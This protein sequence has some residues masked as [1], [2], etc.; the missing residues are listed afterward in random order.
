MRENIAAVCKY[1]F[2]MFRK[3]KSLWLWFLPFFVC[4]GF[5]RGYEARTA[6]DREL[7]LE[8]NGKYVTVSGKVLKREQREDASYRVILGDCVGDDFTLEKLQV[9]WEIHSAESFHFLAIGN[10]ISVS[11]TVQ[12][13]DEA[14]NPGEFDH[15][16][17]ARSQKL[18]YRMFAEKGTLLKNGHSLVREA[19]TQVREQSGVILEKTADP[20]DCGIYRA[21]IL[22]DSGRMDDTL[23]E[24]YRD[25]GAAHLLAVSGLHLSLISAATY[26]VLRKLGAGYGVSGI[27]GT[28]VLMLYGILVGESSSVLRA[29]IMGICGFAASYLGRTYDLMSAWSLALILLLWESPYRMLQAGVQ[30]SFGALAGIGWLAPRLMNG[31][32]GKTWL[33]S[34][35]MQLM[36]IPILLYHDFQYPFYGILLNFLMVPLMGGVVA[37]GTAGIALG[38]V[39]MVSGSWLSGVS[40]W[41]A[42]RLAL[43]GGHMI[44]AWYEFCCR[45]AGHLPGNVIVAGRPEIWKIGVYYGILLVTVVRCGSVEREKDEKN[46]AA[47]IWSKL[48]G[49]FPM[50]AIL[51]MLFIPVPVSGLKV[52]F[53]DVGQGDGICIQTGKISCLMDGGSTDQKQLGEY[54]LVPFLHSQGITKVDYAIVSHGDADHI[55]GLQYL[56]EKR[57]VEIEHLILPEAGRGED[58]YEQLAELAKE[59][60]CHVHWMVRG[61]EICIDSFRERKKLIFTCLSPEKGMKTED[62]NEHSVVLKLDYENFHMLLTGDM[63][64]K[65]EREILENYDVK[66]LGETQVLKVAHHGSDTSSSKSWIQVIRP[67]WA[68]ISY[69]ENNRYGH[70][71]ESVMERLRACQTKIFETAKNGAIWLETDGNT[72]VWSTFK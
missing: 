68:V 8:L 43:A 12:S 4:A 62:K 34:F 30:L 15:R 55:S 29:L 45:T 26:A 7:A 63:T 2:W 31:C 66:L 40:F 70:P 71:K 1:I 56:F 41:S 47:M 39:G 60:G 13:F 18:N 5:W 11:G 61:D 27:V 3:G 23:Y 58:V 53:L 10:W 32:K 57:E 21:V 59:S 25:S 14:C 35:S 9:Y 20:K 24:L 54:R 48:K 19:L 17:Y 6:C 64:D 44:L 38:A 52:T 16:L 69:G 33:V 50:T 65:N 72:I 37:S 67:K 46:N 36:T 22:G 49:L 28:I 51:L 42:S